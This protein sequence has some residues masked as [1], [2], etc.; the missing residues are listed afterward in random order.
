MF[1]D[2]YAI[3]QS[4]IEIDSYENFEVM[5]NMYEK[6]KEVTIYLTTNKELVMNER[7]ER[8]QIE[9]IYQP[10]DE[11]DDSD[12][13]QNNSKIPTIEVNSKFL[14]KVIFKRGLNHYA[15]KNEFEYFV[16]KSKPN[17]FTARL[18]DCQTHILVYRATKELKKWIMKHYNVEVPYLRVFRGKEQAYTDMYGKWEDSFVM[19]DAFKEEICNKNPGSIVDT[20]VEI[21]GDQKCFQCFFISPA[22]CSRDFVLVFCPY[23]SL[24]GCPLKGKFTGVLVSASGELRNQPVINLLDAIIENLMNLGEFEICRSNENRAAIKCKGKRW[25]EKYVDEYFTIEK[26]KETYAMEIALMLA[27]DE[28]VHTKTQEKIYPPLMKHPAG[29]PRKNIIKQDDEKKKTQMFATW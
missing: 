26:L 23:V 19:I 27:M 13:C 14:N 17:R 22:S 29:R 24:D 8:G 12:C 9:D 20:D 1:V 18:R 21:S 11:D 6:E 3:E 15:L 28:W 4:F 2:K 5:L 10:Q 16:E 7:Q 25:E